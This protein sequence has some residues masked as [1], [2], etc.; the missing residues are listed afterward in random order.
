MLKAM[1]V[2]IQKKYQD[3]VPC[4]FAYKVVC[5]DDRFTKPIVVYRGEN[6]A[7]EFIKAILKEYKY[8]KKVMN[9]HFNENMVMSEEEEHL[10]Q[11]SNSYWICE[12]LI[13]NDEEKVI[14]HCHV[15]GKFRD[16]AHWDCNINFQ[17]TKKIPVIFYNLRGYDSHLIFNELDKLMWKLVLYQMG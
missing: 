3:H 15:T 4:S 5:I 16:A 9:K 2:L 12:K 14:D 8:C 7:Y 11:Q 17:L 13:G 1:K 10:F 6:A